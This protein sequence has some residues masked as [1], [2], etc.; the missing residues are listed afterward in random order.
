MKHGVVTQAA[1]A[2]H[3][4]EST[5]RRWLR[6]PAFSAAYRSLRR[7]VTE[8]ANGILQQASEEAAAR[9]V[10]MMRDESLPASIKL[11]A[12]VQVLDRSAAS[13]IEERIASLEESLESGTQKERLRAI[14]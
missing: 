8:H 9:L 3:V 11:A 10:M 14:K 4:P 12:T 5:L 1:N 13:E 7:R 2:S 6:E